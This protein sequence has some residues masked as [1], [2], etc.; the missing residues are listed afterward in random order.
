[1]G[2]RPQNVVPWPEAVLTTS[3][4]G[5]RVPDRIAGRRLPHS[6]PSGPPGGSEAAERAPGRGAALVDGGRGH[7]AVLGRCALNDDALAGLEVADRAAPRDAH[8]GRAIGP[9]PY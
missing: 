4:T 3:G 1:M 5:V 9:D 8:R 7:R 2:R 6:P